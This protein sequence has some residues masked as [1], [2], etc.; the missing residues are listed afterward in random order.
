MKITSRRRVQAALTLAAIC[1][2]ACSKGSLGDKDSQVIATVNDHEITDTQLK[3][4][5][6]SAGPV[7][8][9]ADP[10]A[11]K[12]ALDALINEELLVQ[13][14]MNNKLDRDPAVVRAI[15]NARR[16]ILVRAYAE[17][18]V[19]PKGEIAVAAKQE[20]YHSNPLLF[21]QRK[22]YQFAAFNL[23]VRDVPSTLHVELEQTHTPDQ[24]RDLLARHQLKFTTQRVSRAAEE[25][26]PDT[27]PQFAKA[28]VGDVLTGT[29]LDGR[30]MLL[31]LTGVID[32]PLDFDQASSRI[33]QYLIASRDRKALDEQVKEAKRVAKISYSEVVAEIQP[34]QSSERSIANA[35]KGL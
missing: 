27:L 17:R 30:T 1:L 5:M 25:L 19:F 21:E 22:I 7:A 16:Q 33:E 35:V 6:Y 10:A 13:R 15:A 2:S 18:V 11:K 9:E 14:A 4:A 31:S 26:P 29:Q 28:S 34:Q 3:E 23:S 12:Q 8:A 24:V 20:Y 32:A